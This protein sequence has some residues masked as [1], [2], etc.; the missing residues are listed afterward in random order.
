MATRRID[1]RAADFKALA[2]LWN[3]F[4]PEKY[5]LDADLLKQ[6]TVNSPL[7]DWGASSILMR[8]DEPTA[9]AA[10]KKSAARL[11][12]GPDEDE[13]HLT[14]IAYDESA[15]AVDILGYAKS[16]LRNRGATR[17]AFGRDSRHFFPG[18]PDE[19]KAICSFL[20][21]EGFI[22]GGEA[23]DLTR[24]LVNY[25]NPAK[26]VA[27]GEF[28]RLRQEDRSSLNHFFQKN[29]SGRWAHDVLEKAAVDGI[30]NTV[31]GLIL[32][33]QVQG[34]SLLQD[35]THSLCI[36]GAVWRVGLGENWG[37]LGPIG[38]SEEIRG[39]GFG[40]ALLGASLEDLKA[41][42]VRRC[43]IDWTGLVDFYGKHGFEVTNRYL[44]SQLW[45]ERTNDDQ[46]SE[47]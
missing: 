7:F 26:P 12:K 40:N 31:F 5:A 30:E 23:V 22:D 41:R 15:D 27:D 42:G 14:A 46:P 18:C 2:E 17:L 47:A 8:D 13:A 21:V 19:V 4:Y 34:F 44:Y 20:T 25:E 10:I 37:S 32:D 6:N 11:Y 1:F 45:L 16:I 39:K 35:W 38:I 28:R 9:F 3:R 33:G 29:F 43:I 24:D 36:G